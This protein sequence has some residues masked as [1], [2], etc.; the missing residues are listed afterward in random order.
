MADIILEF[1]VLGGSSITEAGSSGEQ[2]YRDIEAISKRIEE[3]VTKKIK[4]E[5]DTSSI[6]QAKERLQKQ[7]ADL[8]DLQ[9]PIDF[10]LDSEQ[11]QSAIK[12][13][14]KQ[15]KG[16]EKSSHSGTIDTDIKQIEN[17]A[18]EAATSVERSE[19]QIAQSTKRTVETVSSAI[20]GELKDLNSAISVTEKKINDRLSGVTLAYTDKEG[21]RTTQTIGEDSVGNI[22]TTT[23]ES[24]KELISGLGQTEKR[25]Q[26]LKAQIDKTFQNDALDDFGQ[27]IEANARVKLQAVEA[28]VDRV[29]SILTSSKNEN[30]ENLSVSLSNIDQTIADTR[31]WFNVLNEC[32]ETIVQID[33]QFS[34]ITADDAKASGQTEAYERQ[35]LALEEIKRL[36]QEV[37]QGSTADGKATDS[38]SVDNLSRKLHAAVTNQN[39]LNTAVKT[40]NTEAKKHQNAT[41]QINKIF[42]EAHHYFNK[43][44]SG[45]ESN[46]QL[47]ERWWALLNKIES[48]GFG[49]DVLGA[50]NELAQLQTDSKLAG[51][52]VISLHSKLGKL[53]KDHFGAQAATAATGLILNALHN[54]YGYVVEI[55]SAMTE[56]KKVTD[57]TDAAYDRFLSDIPQLAKAVGAS[58]SDVVNATADFARLGYDMDEATML[59]EA[60]TVYKNV[61]DGIDSIDTASKSIISTMKAFGIAAEDAMSIVDKFN[62]VGNNFAISSVGIGEA[63][64]RSAAT[65][66][67][68]GNSIEESIALVTA[69]NTV[70]QDPDVVGTAMK[71]ISMYLRA[72]KTDAEAAGIET[73]GMAESVSKLREE[74]KSLTG[75]DIMLDDK[76]FKSTY[77]ILSEISEVWSDLSDVTQSNVMER[78]AGK[79]QGNV[80]ASILNNWKDAEEAYRTA[81]DSEG[82]ALAENEKYLNS[83]E[84]CLQRLK[85]AYEDLSEAILGDDLI[86]NVVGGLTNV[87]DLLNNISE[88]PGNSITGNIVGIGVGELLRQEGIGLL[89]TQKDQFGN[90]HLT[91]PVSSWFKEFKKIKGDVQE[92]NSGLTAFFKSLFSVEAKMEPVT[93]NA[94]VLTGLLNDAYQLAKHPETNAVSLEDFKA[95]IDL[96]EVDAQYTNLFDQLDSD[97]ERWI[98]SNAKT[99]EMLKAI[100]SSSEDASKGINKYYTS[101]K[102]GQFVAETFGAKLKSLGSNIASFGAQALAS[103]LISWGISALV[104]L[105][106]DIVHAEEQA[107]EKT[108]ELS[109]TYKDEQS[110]LEALK[111]EYYDI[112][113]S[114]K[115]ES[116]KT[117]ELL[118]WKKKLIEAYGDEKDA[119][120]GVTTARATGEQFFD[121]EAYENAKEY[122]V[123]LG[124]DYQDI[125]DRAFSIKTGLI[126]SPLDPDKGN[127][128]QELEQFGISLKIKTSP[129]SISDFNFTYG[130]DVY[131]AVDNIKKALDY[132]QSKITNGEE[133]SDLQSAAREQMQ[134]LLDEYEKFINDSEEILSGGGEAYFTKLYYE[135]LR[136]DQNKLDNVTAETF[137]SWKD[138]F[139]GY[140]NENAKNLLDDENF[141]NI[142]NDYFDDLFI[143]LFPN[144]SIETGANGA[145]LR[146]KSLGKSLSDFKETLSD[147]FSDQSTIQSAFDKIQS[148]SSLSAD[149]VR[150]LIELCPELASSFTKTADGYTIDA[151]RLIE[152]NDSITK[153]IRDGVAERANELRE[154]LNQAKTINNAEDA[155]TV[156]EGMKAAQDELQQLEIYLSMLGIT[157]SDTSDELKKISNAVEANAKSVKILNTAIDEMNDTGHISASTYAD[158]IEAGGNFTDC[159]EIQNGQLVL[160]I[161]KLKELEAQEYKN[162]IAANN[163]RVVEL[164]P[165]DWMPDISEQIKNLFEQNKVLQ[166]LLDDL[167]AASGTDTG[168]NTDTEDNGYDTALKE[169]D[170]LL[171]RGLISYQ[172]YLDKKKRLIKE[173]YGDDIEKKNELLLD[174]EYSTDWEKLYQEE[175]D[176]W[177]KQNLDYN[178]LESR[179]GDIEKRKT[180]AKSYFFGEDS[181]HQDKTTYKSVMQE[182]ADDELAIYKDQLDRGIITTKDFIERISEMWDDYADESGDHL[183]DPS[184]VSDN[185][186]LKKLYE[187]AVEEWER[188]NGFDGSDDK[189]KAR[190]EFKLE[191]IGTLFYDDKSLYYDIETYR[192][193]A[194]EAAEDEL[195][196]LDAMLDKGLISWSQYV[197]GLDDIKNRYKDSVGNAIVTDEDIAEKV[198]PDKE[199]ETR[200][201]DWD[202]KHEYDFRNEDTAIDLRRERAEE[203]QRLN[204]EIFGDPS[205]ENYDP[206]KWKENLEA[207]SDYKDQTESIARDSMKRYIEESE[208]NDERL[209][210]LDKEIEALEEKNDEL[211]K[212]NELEEKELALLEAKQKLEEAS[213]NRNQLI[214]KDGG[215][216]YAIDQEA[217]QDASDAVKDA[218]NDL[219]ET[220]RQTQ[221]DLL[222]EERDG[223]KSVYELLKEK[224]DDL[225]DNDPAQWDYKTADALISKIDRSELTEAQNAQLTVFLNQK[226]RDDL[227]NGTF[228]MTPAEIVKKLETMPS[229]DHLFWFDG[230]IQSASAMESRNLTS[231]NTYNNRSA[232]DQSI[233][234]GDIHISVQGDSTEEMLT[235]F[236]RQLGTALQTRLPQV[237]Y[238]K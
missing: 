140:I 178:S 130:N 170:D 150:K 233:H 117:Q 79:R 99:K 108:K 237:L 95:A 124:D 116:E 133:L 106:D 90:T 166:Y 179:Q 94:S 31:S 75:V 55:D 144:E 213:R 142:A 50:R 77:Q 195:S 210:Q 52:E 64:E 74:L 155:K 67:E 107:I 174:V 184:F 202:T 216:E 151:E 217:Y 156:S 141:K 220:Q 165:L 85:V 223:I 33:N 66:A 181:K 132:Y 115:T 128:R 21:V 83:I 227:E 201:Y 168:T 3:D 153:D 238:R 134:S 236:A 157:A 26:S 10:Q 84:G 161:Q 12:K 136:V 114:N 16:G 197:D 100:K 199:Y 218:E 137:G 4:F 183:L 158:I 5:F 97:A 25:L 38:N 120:E 73:D 20:K 30:N 36:Q 96:I 182:I 194:K 109:K 118:K 214:F 70:I 29:K 105:I 32:Q 126:R 23:T 191:M 112:V 122:I 46:V 189:L 164:R 196:A 42:S 209:Q 59:A 208:K 47:T 98:N 171:A 152:A 61:G 145:S 229:I 92:A 186:D 54:V 135:F 198:T 53:F 211:K 43:Y 22:F 235:D 187:D 232:T 129:D 167:Y 190:A 159:L 48:G 162:A 89:T 2:M 14:Q 35:A 18:K 71:T 192:E 148:G 206:K 27:S 221:I 127:V 224:L 87:I 72:A 169:Y 6:E 44:Q 24:N 234:V 88:I 76:N 40:Y 9:I 177:E 56:L 103:A 111:Q 172:D 205:S 143:D 60:A 15:I 39:A 113:D 63:L 81:L 212:A 86:K 28:Q 13:A 17:E 11:I 123:K 19:E 45:I 62:I 185:I 119:I 93:K 203:M 160:N 68:A 7:V 225:G 82:S 80:L 121:K 58:I 163:L 204:D 57:E 91:S 65:L 230:T 149:E 41:L 175:L 222:T 147:T 146:L 34:K 49:D 176:K 180:L 78:L 188:E 173:T 231:N 125:V 102:E 139:W 1:G 215:F 110:S 8:K 207:I 154:Y 69:A 104:G 200:L 131:E 138:S 37:L 51:A 193:L 101:V 219:A 226:L 228:A